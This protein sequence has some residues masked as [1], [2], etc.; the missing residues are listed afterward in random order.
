MVDHVSFLCTFEKVQIVVVF[1]GF[2][3]E[4]NANCGGFRCI[5]IWLDDLS[6]TFLEVETKGGLM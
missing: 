1:T 4:W 5:F 2:F 3:E 6:V